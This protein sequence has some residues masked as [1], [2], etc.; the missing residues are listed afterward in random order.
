[1]IHGFNQD[2][3]RAIGK[4]RLNMLIGDTKSGALF[5]VIDARTSYKLLLGRP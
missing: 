2:R 1:M 3:Q 5:H 4:I